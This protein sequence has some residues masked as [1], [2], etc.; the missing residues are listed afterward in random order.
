MK[1]SFLK[2]LYVQ[3]LIA[4]TIG[5]LLGHFYPE[6]AVEMRP[7]GTAFINLI[8]MI[9]APVIFCTVVTG[10]AGMENLKAVG[11][12][13]GIALGYFLTVTTVALCVGLV[14]VNIFQPGAGMN[15][16]V[17]SFGDAEPPIRKKRMIWALS[18]S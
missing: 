6:I 14:V 3:V 5:I 10:I 16:D 9:I 7:L 1:F 8:K 13:G 17:S 2:I 15:I 11:R 4:I 18:P 12:T